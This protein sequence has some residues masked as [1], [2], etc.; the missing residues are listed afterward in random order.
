MANNKVATEAAIYAAADGL[1]AKGEDPTYE[2][3]IEVLGGGSNSTI[4]PH[5]NTWKQINC[6]PSR[7]TPEH[8]TMHAKIL[9]E[10]IWAA[11]LKDT[12]SEIERAKQT[13]DEEIDRLN[14]ALSASIEIGHNLEGLRDGMAAQIEALKLERLEARLELRKVEELK[15]ALA[16]A[17]GCVETRR[18]ECALLTQ[19]VATLRG[20]NSAL[21]IQGTQ[22]LTQ[23]SVMRSNSKTTNRRT[24]QPTS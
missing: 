12:Q 20:E 18:Q 16:Q 14:R 3:I 2:R 10:A 23:I 19:E 24:R 13:T 21:K 8:V 11:A 15:T 17:L 9:T 7:P 5:L 4:G 22:L 6:P 1:R